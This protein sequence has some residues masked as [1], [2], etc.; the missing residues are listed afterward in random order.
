VTKL[1]WKVTIPTAVVLLVVGVGVWLLPVRGY[2]FEQRLVRYF[3]NGLLSFSSL[4][5]IGMLVAW[6]TKWRSE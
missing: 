5:L 4:I 2:Y 6:M 3:L 1:S